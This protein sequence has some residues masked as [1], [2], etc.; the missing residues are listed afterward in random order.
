MARAGQAGVG[1]DPPCGVL[2][3]PSVNTAAGV[4]QPT[5]TTL[6]GMGVSTLPAACA[7]APLRSQRRT[8]GRLQGGGRHAQRLPLRALLGPTHAAHLA[9]QALSKAW[10]GRPRAV[11][12]CLAGRRCMGG[13]AAPRAVL[14]AHPRA[15]L[16]WCWLP[17]THRSSTSSSPWLH[18]SRRGGGEGLG[19]CGSL[20]CT[21]APAGPRTPHPPLQLHD[22]T[23]QH[24]RV[25]QRGPRHVAP[26]MQ[27]HTRAHAPPQSGAPVQAPAGLQPLAIHLR[28]QRVSRQLSVAD[29]QGPATV[30]PVGADQQGAVALG[31]HHQL[32]LHASAH[33]TWANQ[34][35]SRAA[36]SLAKRQP[37]RQAS[38]QGHGM[39]G[40]RAGGGWLARRGAQFPPVRRCGGARRPLGRRTGG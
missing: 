31:S 23:I 33:G 40:S 16:N 39:E 4:G 18:S 20:R 34:L 7:A 17:P 36:P 24:S 5:L 9:P 38:R 14:A 27:A 2:G 30:P 3:R 10:V 19:R 13:P 1:P 22:V 25:A 35:G 12:G 8:T 28:S 21:S 29:N 32:M 37:G 15:C 26:S 6:P 11:A